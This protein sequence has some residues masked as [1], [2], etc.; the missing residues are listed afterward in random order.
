M[1]KAAT[2]IAFVPIIAE[3][4]QK[5]KNDRMLHAPAPGCPGFLIRPVRHDEDTCGSPVHKRAQSEY[6]H[7]QAVIDSCPGLADKRLSCASWMHGAS[8]EFGEDS[9]LMVEEKIAHVEGITYTYSG[10]LPFYL[11]AIG[12]KMPAKTQPHNSKSVAGFEIILAMTILLVLYILRHK[13]FNR[14]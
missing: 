1:L 3:K 11:L 14:R 4:S 8:Y 7:R 9:F 6:Y 13:R 10:N 2:H 5:T 12:E